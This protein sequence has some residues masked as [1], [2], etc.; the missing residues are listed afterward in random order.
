MVESRLACPFHKHNA[1]IFRKCRSKKL[2]T[3]ADV[4]AHIKRCH[5]QPPFCTRCRK[6]FSG[7]NQHDLLRN[8]IEQQPCQV[9]DLVDVPHGITAVQEDA[10]NQR[11]ELMLS[12]ASPEARRWYAIWQVC[13]PGEP[14]PDSIYIRESS[15]DAQS[16]LQTCRTLVVG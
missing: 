3:T 10:L 4:R 5:L 12:G 9:S 11:G 2:R 8:H 1:L 16:L 13:L 14:F 6:V 15:E 7:K